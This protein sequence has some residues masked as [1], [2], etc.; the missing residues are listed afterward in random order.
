M[1]NLLLTGL[2]IFVG[3]FASMAM[4]YFWFSESGFGRPWWRYQF[5]NRPYADC[6]TSGMPK[7]AC[8][9]LLITFIAMLIQSSLLLLLINSSRGLFPPWVP[10]LAEPFLCIAFLSVIAACCSMPHYAY[11]LKPIPLYCIC[12][13][14]DAAQLTL[15]YLG[16]YVTH[17]FLG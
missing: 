8:N 12:T 10:A 16:I 14:F 2:E 11:T 13:G 6:V 7:P 3:S 4:G 17:S 5:P 1:A 9:P 15:S